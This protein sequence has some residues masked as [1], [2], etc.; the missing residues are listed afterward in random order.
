[1]TTPD[2][3]Y[4]VDAPAPARS[5]AA[6]LPFVVAGVA[7]LLV[8]G[9]LVSILLTPA[10]ASTPNGPV[11]AAPAAPGAPAPVGAAAPAYGSI[12]IG[13]PAPDFT[14]TRPD[15]GS[16]TLSSYRGQKWVWL[17]FWT[18]WC[19]HCKIEMPQMQELYAQY[20]DQGLEI[21]GVDDAEPLAP[22]QKFISSGGYSWPMAMD[23][24][25]AVSHQYRV[26]GLPTHLFVG[27]DGI[28]KYIV[29]G[30][31]ERPQMEQAVKA[32]L[33]AP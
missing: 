20:K 8:G 21:I 16:V 30:G 18:T 29:I 24:N 9:L 10:P 7:A 13:A 17:N 14:L 4:P 27:R 5:A 6:W 32:L 3:E 26:A 31:I 12:K 11:V 2:H 23:F 25:S 15:G 19:P 28:I 33:A 1:M 22:V